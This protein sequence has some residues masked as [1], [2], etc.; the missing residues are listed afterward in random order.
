MKP[1]TSLLSVLGAATLLVTGSLLAGQAPTPPA[2]A[3]AAPAGSSP[4]TAV[5]QTPQ[6]ELT[7]HS[8]PA[9][10]PSFGPAPSFEQLSGGGKVITEQQASAYPPLANDF[11]HADRDRSGGVT[12]AEYERWV[13]QL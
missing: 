1:R 11:L 10:A 5:Y 3:A 13:K 8:V 9:P 4:D 6:G 2:A 7:V 12:K